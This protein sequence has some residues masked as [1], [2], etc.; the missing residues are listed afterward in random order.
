MERLIQ[1]LVSSAVNPESNRVSGEI[2][3]E[4]PDMDEIGDLINEN[5]AEARMLAAD[6]FTMS[7]ETGL[8]GLWLLMMIAQSEAEI[9]A[10]T[11]SLAVDAQ[12]I[13]TLAGFAAIRMSQFENGQNYK[14]KVWNV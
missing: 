10:L 9:S 5:P 14:G 4:V 7:I 6:K 3:L 8:R 1:Q 13:V 12:S 2:A 11:E